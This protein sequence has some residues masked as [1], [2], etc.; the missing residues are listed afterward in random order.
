MSESPA[1]VPPFVRATRDSGLPLSASRDE[2]EEV[3]GDLD[4]DDGDIVIEHDGDSDADADP[5]VHAGTP[6]RAREGL[7]PTYRMRAEP[8]YVEALVDRSLA[9]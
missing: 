5:D 3:D 6:A 2:Q 4:D 8:H 7:P 9:A 1:Y